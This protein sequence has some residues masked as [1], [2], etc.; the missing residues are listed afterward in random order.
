[1]KQHLMTVFKTIG[2]IVLLFCFASIGFA[3]DN[4]AVMIPAYMV[5]FLLIFVGVYFYSKTHQRRQEINPATKTLIN[6]ILGG[7]LVLVALYTPV[8]MF[9]SLF[10]GLLSFG[11]GI[12]TVIGTAILVGLGVVSV[13]LINRSRATS[14][15]GYILLIVLA[16]VPAIV[17]MRFDTSY[18]SLGMAYYTALALALLSWWGISLFTTKAE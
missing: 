4:A 13:I 1:M 18:G 11:T 7:F 6:K 16:F 14:I 17:I 15:A 12:V 8:R 10:P 3:T 5:F 9:L 2:W